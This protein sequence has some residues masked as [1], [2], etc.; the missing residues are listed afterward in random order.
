MNTKITI[1]N[2]IVVHNPTEELLEYCRQKLVFN[3]PE[4]T[5]KL[6]MG[7]WTGGTPR[8]I[9]LYD[10]NKGL[11][12]LYLPIGCLDAVRQYTAGYIREFDDYRSL[13]DANITSDIIKSFFMLISSPLFYSDQQSSSV[14]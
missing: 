6:Q 12:L 13:V 8:T 4:Y 3:N 10:Y 5:K 2:I 7:F 14:Q 11:N 9:G 1:S